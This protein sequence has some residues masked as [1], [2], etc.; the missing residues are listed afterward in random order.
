M[1]FKR[2]I[3]NKIVPWLEKPQAIVL[4]GMRRTGKTT[5]VKQLLEHVQSDNKIYFDFEAI[6]QRDIFTTNNYNSILTKLQELGL[7]T[8]TKMYVAIDEIQ[9]LPSIA[10]KVKYLSDHYP[11]KFILTGSSSYYLKHLFSE[12]LVGRKIVFDIYPLD[13]GEYLTF[14]QVI[15]TPWAELNTVANTS[16]YAKLGL[17][18]EDY[19]QNG[20][21]PSV[22]LESSSENKKL[23]L[24]EIISSY[25][26]IDVRVLA[27]FESI[28]NLQKT[29]EL[30]ATRVGSRL[31][32]S[33][34]AVAVGVARDTMNN[35][36]EFLEKT[37][38]IY[39]VPV[40]S[41]S[42]DKTVTKAKKVYFCDTG[43]VSFLASASSG[44]LFE[45][46]VYNQLRAFGRVSYFAKHSGQEIDFIV[47]DTYAIEVKETPTVSD[48]QTL[49]RRSKA[50]NLG[51]LALVGRFAPNEF[52]EYVWGGE[53]I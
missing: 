4:T 38:V 31:D 44:A 50:L 1:L 34:L 22:V 15:A 16:H 13:F 18:Y 19:I 11:I 28:G 37:F 45:N 17:Y 8:K 53:I 27:D 49:K 25:I 51:K 24:S 39:R 14:K 47:N 21:F 23:I 5:L 36:L 10:S 32:V 6:E 35:Y 2:K 52:R 41:H 30:L 29:I 9:L 3:F 43:L 40:Y 7:N 48:L 46:A 26:N 42:K 33:K 20:G 12:S